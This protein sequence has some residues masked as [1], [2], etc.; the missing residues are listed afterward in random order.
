M[1]TQQR[2]TLQRPWR[3]LRSLRALVVVTQVLIKQY[4]QRRLQE[5][6]AHKRRKLR[7]QPGLADAARII[8]DVI[9]PTCDV[10]PT[11]AAHHVAE[12]PP[13]G[14]DHLTRRAA[15]PFRRL[16]NTRN[17]DIL[18][19]LPLNDIHGITT[20]HCDTK[21]QRWTNQK[22]NFGAKSEIFSPTDLSL[23]PKTQQLQNGRLKGQLTGTENVRIT[24]KTRG[25]SIM[26]PFIGRANGQLDPRCSQQYYKLKPYH[27]MLC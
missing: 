6:G 7:Q 3:S 12:A 18:C 27:A 26:W 5:L 11:G 20:L 15:G 22:S 17:G 24:F 16:T 1:L 10:T 19:Y 9:Q 14:I 2:A 21:F 8:T 13:G 25:E 23:H 4:G